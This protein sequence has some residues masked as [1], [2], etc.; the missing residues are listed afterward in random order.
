MTDTAKKAQRFAPA[1]H[2]DGG[3]CMKVSHL[4]GWV[5][6]DEHEEMLRVEREAIQLLRDEV[7]ELK[8]AIRDR[9]LQD[10]ADQSGMEAMT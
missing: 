1:V 8:Q 10:L 2:K 4:G 7:V 3:L 9:E 5:S 6:C